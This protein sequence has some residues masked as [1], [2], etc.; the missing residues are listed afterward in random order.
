[1]RCAWLL[2]L[3]T[4]HSPPPVHRTV[5]LISFSLFSIIII[6]LV[7]CQPYVPIGLFQLVWILSPFVVQSTCFEFDRFTYVRGQETHFIDD[8]CSSS[9]A[10]F[11]PRCFREARR[12]RRKAFRNIVCVLVYKS[13]ILFQKYLRRFVSCDITRN[14]RPFL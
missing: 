14:L 11:V 8:S 7:T 1:M 12:Q 5:T 13:C 3:C 2:A 9:S 10:L 6:P 4:S